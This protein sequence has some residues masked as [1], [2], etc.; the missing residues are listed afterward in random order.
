MEILIV[1]IKME[2]C[3]LNFLNNNGNISLLNKQL[4]CQGKITREKKVQDRIEYSIIDFM[5]VCDKVFPFVK[6]M[7]IDENRQYALTN[8][9]QKKNAKFQQ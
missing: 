2:S 9:Y 3:F 4:F 7:H 1:R 6:S 8:L 5:I